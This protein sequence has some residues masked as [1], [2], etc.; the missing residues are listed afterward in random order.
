MHLKHK[1]QSRIVLRLRQIVY[2][3]S[4]SCIGLC[5]HHLL[6][7]RV[8]LEKSPVSPTHIPPPPLPPP[9][10]TDLSPLI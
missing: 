2:L 7:Y 5:E 3:K 1:S 10:P 6:C 8:V 9:S 4:T